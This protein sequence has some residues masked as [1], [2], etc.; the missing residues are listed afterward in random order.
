MIRFSIISAQGQMS[1]ESR[2]GL[3]KAVEK[4]R[5]WAVNSDRSKTVNALVD[6]PKR[7]SIIGKPCIFWNVGTVYIAS[8]GQVSESCV[9]FFSAMKRH[10]A[11]RQDCAQV[12]SLPRG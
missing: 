12:N 3:W 6:F 11:G 4:R 10:T 9:C 7:D 1:H 2:F 5:G 8:C